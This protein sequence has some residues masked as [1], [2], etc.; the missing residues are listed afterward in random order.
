MTPSPGDA[1]RFELLYRAH[2]ADIVRFVR[3]RIDA[4]SAEEV[5]ADTFAT[6]WRRLEKVP[7]E[8]LPWLYVVAGNLVRSERR[9]LASSRAKAASMAI[10][11]SS[12]GA[13]DP[14]D[15]F[16]E[17][18]RVLCAFNALSEADR[19]ALRLVAW[20]GLDHRGA[21]RVSGT[22]R[23]AFTM[24]VSRARRRLATALSELD[25]AGP[26]ISPA[27]EMKECQT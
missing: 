8:P 10:V 19:E 2:Y 4:A 25:E 3:R 23:V 14:A 26:A 13:R 7:A 15:T 17:R 6:A 24:R 1:Q 27:T 18:D 12:D 5:V 11:L 9:A 21:A 16:A 22:T 20:E